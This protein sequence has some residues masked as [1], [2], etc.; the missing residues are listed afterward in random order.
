M[1]KIRMSKE[2]KAF[3][4]LF[5]IEIWERFGFYGMQALLVIFMVKYLKMSDGLADNTFSAFSALIYTFVLFGGYIGDKV[6]GLKRTMVL[7]AI[8]LASGYLFLSFFIEKYLFI[9]LG[10]IIAGNALFKANPSAVVSKLYE[11]GSNKLDSVYTIYYMSINLGALLSTLLTPW[12]KDNFG[13]KPAFLISFFGMTIAIL[14]YIFFQKILA[15]FGSEPDFKKINYKKFFLTL[16]GSF[17]IIILSA[18]LLKHLVITHILL[19]LS[20]ICGIVIFIMEI[21]NAESKFS[22]LSM[23]A[24]LILCFEALLFFVLYQQMPT[25]LTLFAVRNTDHAILGISIPPESFQALNPFWIMAGSPLL[26]YIYTK[27]NQKGRDFSLPGKF[28]LG[29]FL[30]S[31][32]FLTLSAVSKF[33]INEKGVI[34][35]NWLILTYGLQ[36]FGELLVSGLGLSMVA[37]LVPEKKAAFMMGLW[38]VFQATGMVL[39]GYIASLAS[40]PATITDPFQTIHIY[41]I[42]FFKLGL[43]TLIIALLMLFLTPFLKKI[44][45][46]S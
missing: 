33:F 5:S 8:T 29:M 16:L 41:T 18:F 32:G 2:N 28:T 14:N 10:I 43:A 17:T 12:V 34:S 27:L 15:P 21:L 24:C 38:F 19:F 26:A 45:V 20:L 22:K 1:K 25:S 30:C 4:I 6:L 36:S 40:I 35:G 7:G 13:W 23:V 46:K 44:I 9:A 11:H 3:Y 31:L 42:L 37:R 39:G